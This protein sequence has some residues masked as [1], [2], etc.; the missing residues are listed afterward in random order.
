MK[1]LKMKNAIY[2]MKNT[3]SGTNSRLETAEE[4]N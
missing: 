4:K 2:G 3:L 1:L